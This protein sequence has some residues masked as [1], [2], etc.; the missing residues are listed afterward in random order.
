M[1]IGYG[2][3]EDG[4]VT[5][6]TNWGPNQADTFILST[7]PVYEYDDLICSG[8]IG[9]NNHGLWNITRRTWC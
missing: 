5:N 7:S 1:K 6:Y 2:M 9:S 8:W 3:H 4:N